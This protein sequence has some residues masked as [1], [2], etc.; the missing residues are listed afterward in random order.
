MCCPRTITLHNKVI[1]RIE[2][3][4]GVGNHNPRAV[5]YEEYLEMRQRWFVTARTWNKAW[6]T[7]CKHGSA[8]NHKEGA[9]IQM[10]LVRTQPD[11][12]N[13]VK[14][15]LSKASGTTRIKRACH[16]SA[17]IWDWIPNCI[18]STHTVRS[19]NQFGRFRTPRHHRCL[20]KTTRSLRMWNLAQGET[21]VI[22][23]GLNQ[24]LV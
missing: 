16:G 5:Q 10:F 24:W 21:L 2:S 6:V 22:R 14:R 23:G 9:R 13:H 7:L 19:G 11:S 3:K 4:G 17:R 20:L 18:K 1:I 8:A 12:S 15:K